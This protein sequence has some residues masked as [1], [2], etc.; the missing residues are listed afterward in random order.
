M[1]EPLSGQADQ[2]GRTYLC[3]VLQFGEELEVF[4]GRLSKAQPWVEPEVAGA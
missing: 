4:G 3:D 2:D 1:Y